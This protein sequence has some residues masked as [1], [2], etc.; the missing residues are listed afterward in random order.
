[1]Q[2]P[3]AWSLA[4]RLRERLEE[5][6]LLLQHTLEASEVERR[7]IASDL[8]DGVVQDLSGVAYALSA[9]ARSNPA[10]ADDGSAGLAET[11]RESVRALRS[12]VIDLSP[13]NLRDEGLAS[14]L[15]DLV[16]RARRRG[17]D[18]ELDTAE[19]H[20][21]PPERA[22]ALVYRAAQEALRNTTQHAA[23]TA[24]RVTVAQ[25]N[26]S[27]LMTVRDDGRGF[28]DATLAAREADGHVGLRA[29]RG[30]VA[31]GGGTVRVDSTPGMGTTVAVEVP[32]R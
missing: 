21:E 29:L 8:H 9:R 25:G 12:L 22:A 14:A 17:L 30:L 2:L 18:A 5:R 3:L 13:P 4:R 7:Q 19:L 11:V 6:E 15:L 32:V 27:L 24:V 28:D 20:G 23:A 16:D 26:G 10:G 31:D 1:V